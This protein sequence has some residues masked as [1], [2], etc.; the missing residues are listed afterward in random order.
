M[1]VILRTLSLLSQLQLNV[2]GSVGTLPA[3]YDTFCL[4]ID[5]AVG[6]W[7]I[8]KNFLS[9]FSLSSLRSSSYTNYSQ[10]G[11]KEIFHRSYSKSADRIPCPQDPF[12]FFNT[13]TREVN[14]QC[15]EFF[16]H[17][18]KNA[19]QKVIGKT[20]VRKKGK[21]EVQGRELLSRHRRTE[22]D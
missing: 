4:C 8:R 10:T 19:K 7:I 17:N 2:V 20:D 15:V 1:R 3:V 12:F 9:L 6:R 16:Y 22:G 18:T 14:F 13:G 11:D 21:R 5:P